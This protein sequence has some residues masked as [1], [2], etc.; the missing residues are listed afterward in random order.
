MNNEFLAKVFKWFGLGLLITF[1]V[2]YVVST[3]ERLIITI[4]TGSTPFIILLLELVCAIWL[5]VRI[6]KMQT[7]T[8]IVLYLGY[9]ALTGLTFSSIFILYELSSIIWVFL[10]TA[11]VFALFS[12]IGTRIK[13]NLNNFGVFLFIG[14]LSIIIL[15][16]INIFLMNNTIDMFLCI[17]SLIVFIGYVAYDMQKLNRLNTNND[18]IA[19][20]GAFN[21]YLDFINIFIRLLQLF[22]KR[23]D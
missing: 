14:L 7:S 9:T 21:I 12:L 5:S 3:S 23:R 2:A 4:F 20:I 17:V 15:E 22:G 1:L 16:V 19:I 13:T 11:I 8:A 18:N 10:A 6:H